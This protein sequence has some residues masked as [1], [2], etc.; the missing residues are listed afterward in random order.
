MPANPTP[1]PKGA[2]A[3]ALAMLLGLGVVISGGQAKIT[4]KPPGSTTTTGVT[5]T[6]APG[7]TTTTG[8]STTTT[9]V[10]GADPFTQRFGAPGA[11]W[12]RKVSEFGPATGYLASLKDRFWLYA[13]YPRPPGSF[14]VAF[15]DYSVPIH[16]LRTA[17]STNVV[18]AFQ[19]T[20]YQNTSSILGQNVTW[21]AFIPWSSQW[22]WGTGFDRL[23]MA[24]DPTTGE[25]WGYN[26]SD[27][28]L[29]AFGINQCI[30]RGLPPFIPDGPN[31][32][33]GFNE[34]N[35]NHKCFYGVARNTTTA[36][37]NGDAYTFT[38]GTTRVE[39]GAGINKFVGIT[40]AIEVDQGVI[41]HA[42]EFSISST[43]F[44]QPS[45]S[46]AK[47]FS[48]TRAQGG[49]CGFY[50]APATRVEWAQDPTNRCGN[51]TENGQIN[52]QTYNSPT[53][54]NRLKTVPEGLRLAINITDPQIEDWLD[55][56]GYTGAKRR[57]AKIFAVAMRDYGAIVLETGCSGINLET[58]G[59]LDT[60][61]GGSRDLWA[62]NGITD[63][64]GNGN[65]HGDL[66]TGLITQANLYVVNP[67]PG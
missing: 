16:D 50:V 56:R 59:I 21:G 10:P 6:T 55:S 5:T 12:N 29:G 43:M 37:T 61:T 8:A 19:Q 54:Q 14:N 42:L 4:A 24:V 39:R 49:G 22:K 33:A 66:L 60:R 45:C 17:E 41:P 25:Y 38:D 64:S 47:G 48:D 35:P 2:I 3:I 15:K 63:I 58:D 51:S 44:G 40:R 65:P 46:P 36:G 23:M 30:D 18:R 31:A 62:A 9:T 52:P 20:E 53:V 57:T 28:P 1:A 7:A 27:L 11:S 26:G 67:P 32:Q 13:G 34:N